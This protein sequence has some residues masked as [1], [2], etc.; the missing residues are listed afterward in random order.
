MLQL[1]KWLSKGWEKYIIGVVVTCLAWI[2]ASTLGLIARAVDAASQE[3]IAN[4]VARQEGFRE[5]VAQRLSLTTPI[6]CVVAW[7][8]AVPVPEGWAPCDGR[9][10]DLAPGDRIAEVLGDTYGGAGPGKVRLPDFRGMFL[11]GVG[12][13]AGPLGS[14]QQDAFQDHQ[15][16]VGVSPTEGR[17]GGRAHWGGAANTTD[18]ILSGHVHA[19]GGA[20]RASSETRPVNY[21]VHWIIRVK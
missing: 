13:S 20:V 9:A 8:G 6:G 4:Q 12:G 1:E 21:S 16:G 14:P 2:A 17:D 19:D 7:P 10:I 18:L 15:H 11:R 5:A 3:G